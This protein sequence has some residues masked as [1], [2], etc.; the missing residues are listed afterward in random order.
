M[1]RV[2]VDIDGVL[3]PFDEHLRDALVR[4]RYRANS[5]CPPA[6]KWE[7]FTDWLMTREL[8]VDYCDMFT[9]KGKLFRHGAPY[10]GAAEQI[11]RLIKAG[12]E[13]IL[14]TNR[15]FG[16]EGVIQE[17][18]TAWLFE[19][20]F[21]YHE[22][23]FVKDKREIDVDYH[24]EDNTTN[25][26][27]MRGHGVNAWLLTQPW[28]EN[29]LASFRVKSLGEYVDIVLAAEQEKQDNPVLVTEPLR[30]HPWR[31]LPEITPLP[32]AACVEC[33][34]DDPREGYDECGDCQEAVLVDY[35]DD[36]PPLRDAHQ[37]S[38]VEVRITS[39]TGGQ[40]GRKLARFDLIPQGALWKVAELYGKGA[41][42][43][44]DWNW[45]K[46]YA[47]SLSIGALM[48]HL[49]LF[50]QGEDYDKETG[51]HHLTAV[52]FHAMTLLTFEEERPEFD[53][54]F[55]P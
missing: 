1:A 24:I 53:D 13:V 49:S 40:K 46:G 30:E 42:K 27:V 52:V 28:N 20:G 39:P 9:N 54:R 31:V 38:P 15:N 51:C 6:T 55:K 36:A 35:P 26:E 41:E 44:D 19:N 48:R 18:T 34:N 37:W 23:H 21:Q 10:Q 3:Y 25:Y 5:Q 17:A 12:H 29:D 43:Y 16:D 50:L 32:S 7:F 2:G 33:G 22:L 4:G 47:W 14:I 8:F 11:D 45:R